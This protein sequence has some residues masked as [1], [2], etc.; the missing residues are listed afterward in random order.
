MSE[1]EEA[2]HATEFSMPPEQMAAAPEP[3]RVATPASTPPAERPLPTPA[4]SPSTP[5]RATGARPSMPRITGPVASTNSDA[6]IGQ[7]LADRYEIQK[8]LG[9]GGMGAVYLATHMLLEKRVA[10]KILHGEYARKADLV[11]RFIQEAKSASRIRH[12]NVID[13]SDFGVTPD[14]LVFFAM[15]LLEGHDL[16]VE[17]V[18]AKKAKTVIP[19]DRSRKIFLQICAA[20]SAAHAQG[21]IHRDLKPEN[22]YLVDFL[23]N[24]D[25]VKLLDFGIAKLVDDN[26]DGERKLTKTGMLFGTPEYMSPEQAR[27]EPIDHRVDV[28]AMGCI[29]H[30]LLTGRVPFEADNFMGILSM[31]LTEELPPLPVDAFEE[32]GAPPGIAPII[33]KALA[34][35][36]ED[37]WNNIDELANAVRE[38]HGEAAVEAAPVAVPLAVSKIGAGRTRTEWKGSPQVPLQTMAGVPMAKKK[39]LA[40]W[41]AAV[42]I[43]GAG[44]GVAAY[45][46]TRSPAAPPAAVP[47]VAAGSAAVGLAAGSAAAQPVAVPDGPLPAQVRVTLDTTPSGATVYQQ[48]ASGQW[49]KYGKTPMEVEGPGSR[50]VTTYKIELVGYADRIYA[51]PMVKDDSIVLTLVP[52]AGAAVAVGTAPAGGTTTTGGS[53]TSGG[54]TGGGKTGGGTTGG[55]TTTTGGGST[56]TGGGTTTNGGGGTT[57]TG[58]G[59]GT[60]TTAPGGGLMGVDWDSLKKPADKPKDP[61]TEKPAAQPA[62]DMPALKPGS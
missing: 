38:L 12:E 3:V 17:I 32:A 37:R 20:L 25:F 28:Y 23:G 51:L 40:P 35:H 50:D 5:P 11:E 8:K 41:I 48:L 33:E 21:V 53:Q 36:R 49:S 27:G 43:G 58:G 2:A 55:G 24:H 15:E 62:D 26:S 52:V 59:G 19:W 47:V 13:I 39:S 9:E 34:K 45:L 7:V 31:H 18:R 46:A 10:L 6:L 16:H 22:I 29:L 56:T 61:P 4:P 60:T 30:Q 54:K 57:T 1:V 14:G 42:A 44:A